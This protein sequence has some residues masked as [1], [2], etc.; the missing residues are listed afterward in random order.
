M[1][2]IALQLNSRLKAGVQVTPHWLLWVVY[3]TERG[4]TYTGDE[5]W[6]SFEES[7]PAWNFS[8]RDKIK[9]WFRKFH[10]IYNGVEPSGP[11]AAHRRIISWPITHAIL[12]QYLQRE[13]VRALYNLRFRLATLSNL[14]PTTIGRLLSANAYA[15][16]R[17]QEFLQQEDL[18]GRI[19]LALLGKPSDDEGKEPL[20]PKT[21][22][23]IVT[24]LKKIRNAGG[25]LNETQRIASDRFQGIGHGSTPLHKPTSDIQK[26]PSEQ[27]PRPDVRPNLL[28]RHIGRGTW[29]AVIDLPDFRG[30]AGLST[31]L[32]S[33]LRS[34]R[35]RVSGALDKK[36][37]GWLLSGSRKAVL[38]TWPDQTKPLIE[39][40]RPDAYLTHL[41]ESECRFNAGPVWLFRVGP[42]GTAL[43]ITG[44][45][46]R[47]GNDYV[48]LTTL[49]LPELRAFVTECT[50]DCDGVKAFKLAIPDAIGAEDSQWLHKI[51]VQVARTI[52]IWPA[53]LPGRNWDGEGRGEWLTTERPCLG[54]LHDHPVETYTL[55]LDQSDEQIIRAGS[56]GQPT[57]LQLPALTVGTHILTIKAGRISDGEGIP[58][59]PLEGHLQIKVRDPDPWTPG[60]VSHSG[61]LVTIDPPDATLDMFWENDVDLSILGPQGH[62]VTFIVRL[63]GPSGNEI[64]SEQFRTPMDLPVNPDAWSKRFAQ[65][66]KRE[67]C[68]W[69]FLEAARGHL[70][71]N[72]DTLGEASLRFERKVSSLRWVPSHEHGNIIL[73]LVDETGAEGDGSE[74]AF[75]SMQ[76]PLHREVYP[77][78]A[79]RTGLT[80]RP[81]GGL[82][83]AQSG[84]QI[85][86][87]AASTGLAADGLQGLSVDPDVDEIATAS[88]NLT[89]ACRLLALWSKARRIGFLADT[90]SQKV[91]DSIVIELFKYICCVRW[92]SAELAYRQNPSSNEAMENLLRA[93][94]SRNPGFATVLYR[95]YGAMNTDFRLASDWFIKLAARHDVCKDPELCIFAIRLA[96]APH[97][98]QEAYGA[99]LDRMLSRIVATPAI[100]RGARLLA[101]LW[102]QRQSIGGTKLLPRWR[103]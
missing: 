32:A 80:L 61:M 51:G 22:H 5:Y 10:T 3:A 90:R 68:A 18:T 70:I 44:R 60:V 19:V 76:H 46:V 89:A 82:F 50:I 91:K 64:L 81:P 52:R 8:D 15:T 17:F 75:Y 88:V 83:W 39:F 49:V 65:F 27:P 86:V 2:D 94:D 78:E 67:D 38:K 45:T 98:I 48:V 84:H 31:Q 23:R 79:F 95:D 36:P 93:V 59:A 72:G 63:E 102:A 62:S 20:Y 41:L 100:L 29:S 12:P 43:E 92:A 56:P 57:Y 66:V 77:P 47:P 21:L 35:C 26:K 24:D 71:I 96:G 73:R 40:D 99:N 4:Y 54:I 58:P 103:W 30:I 1:D 34:A 11:W 28:L 97:R 25:W 55:R 53:G 7:T 85:D 14:E 37:A 6:Q 9:L 13:F 87:V 42:D 16:T 69:K 74:A 33:F 101:V